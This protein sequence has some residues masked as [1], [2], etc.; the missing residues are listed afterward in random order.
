MSAAFC[1]R[2]SSSDGSFVTRGTL[3]MLRFDRP[4]FLAAA[5]AETGDPRVE[6]VR[7]KPL[8][9]VLGDLEWLRG[10]DPFTE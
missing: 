1:A 3:D 8:E 2:A 5:R 4:G 9:A 10:V 6:G 7:F